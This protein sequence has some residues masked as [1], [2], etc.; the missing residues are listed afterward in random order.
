[1]G[2]GA[3]GIGLSGRGRKGGLF[4]IGAGGGGCFG[5]EATGI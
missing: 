3:D 4:G 2:P 1:M 5:V